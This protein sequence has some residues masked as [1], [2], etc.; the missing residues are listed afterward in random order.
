MN[1]VKDFAKAT[2]SDCIKT[3][4]ALDKQ[5]KKYSVDNIKLYVILVRPTPDTAAL[6]RT[7][8]RDMTCNHYTLSGM[9]YCGSS[10]ANDGTGKPFEPFEWMNQKAV[11]ASFPSIYKLT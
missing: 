7:V 5:N 2:S 9:Q 4:K 11:I 3:Y 10:S 1:F 6:H 8:T